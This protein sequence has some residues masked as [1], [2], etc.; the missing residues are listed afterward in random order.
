VE[1]VSI[2]TSVN[3]AEG[4]RKVCKGRKMKDEYIKSG[5]ILAVS[6]AEQAINAAKWDK[7]SPW[8]V[9][10]NKIFIKPWKVD[11]ARQFRKD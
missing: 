7:Q 10:A 11:A 9:L 8:I 5:E 2:Y 6:S 3:V 4:I 1:S